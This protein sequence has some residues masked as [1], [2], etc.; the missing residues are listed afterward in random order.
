MELKDSITT[1]K[2][3]G[4]RKAEAL[5]HLGIRTLED[6]IYSFPRIYEDRRN[7]VLIADLK[8]NESAVFT[9]EVDLITP[10]AFRGRNK[11]MLK[12]LVSD[13]SGS[14]EL[15]FFNGAYLAKSIHVGDIYTFFGKPQINRERLQVIHPQFE[16][17]DEAR[18]GILPIYPLSKGISQR[19]IRR[20]Q[21]IL[22]PLYSKVE[23]V[24]PSGIVSK[25][26]LCTL[27]YALENIHFPE[28]KRKLLE[29]KYR[30][31]FDEFIVLQA[32]LQ[33]AAR[34]N[35]AY[36][37]TAVCDS[38]SNEKEFIDSLPY[39]LTRAQER[40][41]KEIIKDLEGPKCMNRLLQGDVGSGKTA[42]AEI[43]MFKVVANGFQAVMMAPT[44]ILAQQHYDNLK[45]DFEKYDFKVAFLSGTMK[46]ADR[47]E[48]L[49][50][51]AKGSIQILVGT[52]AVIQEGV[53]YKNLGLVITDEQHRFGVNQ[54]VKL[55]EKGRNPN[56][57]VMTA[58]PIPRTLA[59]VLYGDMDVSIIDEMPL[60]RI[61]VISKCV[62]GSEERKKCYDFV[63]R[64]IKQGRQCYVVTPLIDVSEAMDA[65]SAQEV[66]EELSHSFE[67]I[68]LIH[69]GMKANEKDAIMKA[70]N[71]GSIDV[72]VA[73]VVIEVGINVPNASVMVVENSERF[74]LAQLHQLRGRVGR[75]KHQS[76]CFLVIGSESELALKRGQIL[77]ESSDGFYIA[78]KDLTIR[79]PGEIFGTR[80]H[81]IPDMK[82]ADMIKHISV[83]N[84]AKD[85]VKLI[86]EDDPFLEKKENQALKHRIIKLFGKDMLLTL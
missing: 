52:H 28:D 46:A 40:C 25:N 22:R 71:D 47:K 31:V 26:N 65:K 17:T 3:I 7:T 9:G 14:I 64:Q 18:T 45:A 32:G 58:T 61:P 77:E 43:A 86:L 69:G 84:I 67:K 23:D 36:D 76:Y 62:S 10:G 68:A 24:L 33:M 20:I 6:L 48:V 19:E 75:G 34:S 55:K 4:P 80:Q 41:S 82:I 13:A 21:E 38:V 79:G 54:R 60:G 29:A 27:E 44:E 8:E 53:K 73:T 72:L 30:L 59:V 11:R 56:V 15:I 35:C 1:I 81:G 50:G 66:F 12:I 57:L 85:E 37:E 16:K 63:K 49:D 70:F 74:G 2:G 78:E 5:S 39:P 42:V 83:L 51:L